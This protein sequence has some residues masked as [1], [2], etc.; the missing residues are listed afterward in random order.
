MLVDRSLRTMAAL[1]ATFALIMVITCLAYLGDFVHRKNRYSTSVGRNNQ[2]CKNVERTDAVSY[3][4]GTLATSTNPKR[5]LQAIHLLINIA[6]TM[7]L[8]MSN[9]YQQLITSLKVDEIRWMLSKHEDSRVGTNS[10]MTIKHKK[11]GKVGSSLAWLLLIATSLVL[12]ASIPLVSA[13]ICSPLFILTV[14]NICTLL[15]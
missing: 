7:T 2:S 8:G 1:T 12:T 11:N 15:D 13:P 5:L 3:S 9:T 6:A 14:P 4:M 10:P